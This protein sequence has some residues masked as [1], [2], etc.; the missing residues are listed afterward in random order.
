MVQDTVSEDW[1]QMTTFSTGQ[2]VINLTSITTYITPFK[3]GTVT[4]IVTN[5]YLTNGTFSWPITGGVNPISDYINGAPGPS[6]VATELTGTAVVTGGVTVWV[7]PNPSHLKSS[8]IF[9]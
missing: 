4:N 1:W 9:E 7:F 5:V 3:N 8:L 2:S 6:Q